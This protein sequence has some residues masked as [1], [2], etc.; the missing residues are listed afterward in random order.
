MKSQK[1][2]ALSLF[3]LFSILRSGS[4]VVDNMLNQGLQ[5][6]SPASPDFRWDFTPRSC[7][8]MTLFGKLNLNSLTHSLTLYPVLIDSKFSILISYRAKSFRKKQ[9]PI[10]NISI[11]NG[12]MVWIEKSVMRVTDWHHEACRVM[13]N[14]DPEWQIFLSTPYIHDK[15]FFLHT[16]WLTT[17][18]FQSRTCYKVTLF[19]FK[20]SCSCLKK[21]TLPATAIRYVT[22]TS[23]LHKVTTFFDVK[24]NLTWQR[25]YMTSY[26]TNALN[27]LDFYPVLGEIIWVR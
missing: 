24:T 3:H 7:L 4:S 21:S 5:D 20:S 17:F 12:C 10:E 25:R 19:P 18:D 2:V 9:L 6:W 22:L 1:T 23:T 13:Q 11:F 26:T 16:F 15:Y 14:S 8:H 27:A